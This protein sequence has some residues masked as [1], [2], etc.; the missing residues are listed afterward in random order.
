MQLALFVD[1]YY[2]S[3]QYGV[4]FKNDGSDASLY[5]TIGENSDYTIYHE[6][7]INLVANANRTPSNDT[8]QD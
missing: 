8:S 5:D 1:N 4:G 2:G 3:H 7:Q 6:E